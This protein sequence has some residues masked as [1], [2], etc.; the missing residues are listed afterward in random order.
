MAK[1]KNKKSTSNRLILRD[2]SLLHSFAAV[3]AK[4]GRGVLASDIFGISKGALVIA[5]GRIEFAGPMS[6]LPKELAKK[7]TKEISLKGKTVFPA[8]HEC[9]THMVYAGSRSAEFER[10]LSGESYQQ[11]AASGGGIQSTVE[12]TKAASLK[13]L[14][15]T[16]GLRARRFI[17]QGVVSIEFKSGYGLT[18][19]N[20][21]KMLK[22]G[23]T[24]VAETGARPIATFLGA[25]AI[26]KGRTSEDWIEELV[27][28]MPRV[29]K[30]ADRVDIFIEKGYFSL[31]EGRKYAEAA[32]A[33]GLNL[34]VHADQLNRTGAG[35]FAAGA[36]AL[37]ADHLIEINDDDIGTISNSSM[38]AVLL[39]LADLYMRCSYP[40]ARKLIEAGARVALATDFN[41]GTAPS[42]DL[43][44]TGLLARLEMKMSLSEVF[45][46]YTFNAA[47]ALGI[48]TETG[49]L[50]VGKSADLSVISGD[51]DQLFYSAGYM[52]IE[53]VMR[54]GEFLFKK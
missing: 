18:L 45:A 21:F 42:Q 5:D 28:E 54:K 10:R 35:H 41:P 44:L 37:S 27:R 39:P 36:H 25:H 12:N 48:D 3:A 32:K 51:L 19:E 6:A 31:D 46:A 34:V 38:V 17:E 2:I 8:F 4:Q 16:A 49:S 24:A 11:I 22:A 47:G 29:R 1:L 43:A 7:K 14:V 13:D 23:K 20:E 50:E 15:S 26:P 52:P 30:Q 9:H 53:A 33:V 40:P